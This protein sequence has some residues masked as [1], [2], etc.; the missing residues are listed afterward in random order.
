MP[1]K[2]LAAWVMVSGT[3]TLTRSGTG[4]DGVAFLGA[5][6]GV[7]LPAA[8]L[9]GKRLSRASVISLQLHSSISLPLG[10]RPTYLMLV[11]WRSSLSIKSPPLSPSSSAVAFFS[12]VI[13][14][15]ESGTLAPSKATV[16]NIPHRIKFMMSA[17]PSTTM[18]SLAS[19][20]PGPAGRS[21][22]PYFSTLP[23][24]MVS[25]ISL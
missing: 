11:T 19:I 12:L 16:L 1:T 3:S 14:F 25:L 15:I 13:F 21:S 18:I 22:G 23:T 20:S 8:S 7:G 24:F 2:A 6:C 4:G 10:A 17:L 9:I 5:G